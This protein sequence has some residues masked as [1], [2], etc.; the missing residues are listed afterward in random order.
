MTVPPDHEPSKSENT[1]FI[2]DS[3]AELARLV[4]QEHTLARALGGLLPE[5]PDQSAF[6]APFQRVLDAACGSGGWV[7]ELARMYPHLQVMGFDID[8]RMI[9][10]ANTQAHVGGLDNASFQVMDARVP[11]DYPDNFFDLVNARYL[12]V[13]PIEAW[14]R[15]MQELFRIARSGGIIRLTE[16]EQYSL[17]N[18]PAFEKLSGMFIQALKRAGNI[19]SPDGRTTGLTPMLARFLRDAGCQNIQRRPFVIDWSSGMEAHEAIFQDLRVAIKLLQ[20]FLIKMGVTTPEEADHLYRE[21]E[22]EMLSDDFCAL[23]YF[24]TVWGE[25]PES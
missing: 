17:T 2:H 6:L 19:S 10:Y 11:L 20:P 16:N 9:A 4:E 1:Y 21:A 25:K 14:P 23:W 24:L 22:I 8:A 3:A 5:H 7:L 13:I 18:G 12:A 15:V